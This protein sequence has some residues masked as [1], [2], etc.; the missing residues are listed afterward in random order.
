MGSPVIAALRF[1]R[2]SRHGDF[3]QNFH[4][5]R[6]F[7]AALVLYFAALA[8]RTVSSGLSRH[9]EGTSWM[10]LSIAFVL[11]AGAVFLATRRGA[12]ELPSSHSH[13]AAVAVVLGV[14]VTWGGAANSSDDVLRPYS[15]MLSTAIVVLV[16]LMLR[17]RLALAW[18]V[19]AVDI[20]IGLALGPLSDSPNWLTAVLPR[21]SFIALFIAS[22][23]VVLL[24]TQISEMRALSLRRAVDRRGVANLRQDIFERD[25][26]IRRIDARVRPLLTKV[27]SG[28]EI[29]HDDVVDARLLEARL[30]DGIRGRGLDVPRVRHSVWEAR[31]RGVAVT[32]L[33][34]GGLTALPTDQAQAVTNATARVLEDELDHL[35]NGEV[36]ARIGPP[37]RRPVATVVVEAGAVRRRVELTEDGSVSRVI[38]S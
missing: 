8:G 29:S 10:A 30:R 2:H 25:E 4:A 5:T 24:S 1:R 21:A 20:A 13:A 12:H 27:A 31:R 36:I 16:I 26:R 11:L 35:K 38:E 37:G 6:L 23:G 17:N 19:V 34:D 22:A 14:A 32:V 28:S 33:D 18:T 15:P 9:I 3:V 7:A